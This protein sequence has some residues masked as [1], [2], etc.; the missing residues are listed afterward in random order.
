MSLH[1][2][3]VFD[4][5]ITVFG[6]A[7]AVV[8]WF[9]YG[10]AGSS[11]V[12]L[13]VVAVPAEAKINVLVEFLDVGKI[14]V[15]EGDDDVG[16]TILSLAIFQLLCNTVGGFYWIFER[17]AF[18]RERRYECWHSLGDGADVGYLHA[19]V[20][21]DNVVFLEGFV[22]AFSI[23][24]KDWN[25]AE[26]RDDAF[27]KILRALIE[28]VVTSSRHFKFHCLEDLDCWFILSN[29]RNVCRT[30]NVIAC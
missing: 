29:S 8:P 25:I 7:L 1:K 28:F 2:A 21:L 20:I 12:L 10:S 3:V 9:A 14:F 5:L 17:D 22:S 19:V 27:G 16:F 4:A 26:V 6:F 18:D 13:A 11:G 15:H 30:T 23:C 24:G